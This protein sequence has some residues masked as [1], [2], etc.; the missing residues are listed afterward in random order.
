MDETQ[1]PIGRIQA[2][3]ARAKRKGANGPLQEGLSKGGASCTLAGESREKTG[4]P[5]PGHK[6]VWTR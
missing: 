5:D 4:K 2:D 6:S 1:A 3:D